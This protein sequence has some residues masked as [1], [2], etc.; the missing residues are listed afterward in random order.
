[1]L[2]GSEY[3][4][5]DNIIKNNPDLQ[6]NPNELTQDDITELAKTDVQTAVIEENNIQPKFNSEYGDVKIKNETDYGLTEEMLTPN[7]EFNKKDILIFNTHTCES[8]TQSEKYP[9][10]QTGNYRTTDLN[11]TV[12]RIGK[13]LA[14]NLKAYG[15]N[16]IQDT[17]Y[18]DYPAYTGSYTRSLQTVQNILEDNT[19]NRYGI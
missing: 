10:E 15:F 7:L 14:S 16:V 6:I 18:H 4:L 12:S 5:I 13:E 1:M 3:K 17:T 2:L 19:R 11:Y 9:Y 8:Y